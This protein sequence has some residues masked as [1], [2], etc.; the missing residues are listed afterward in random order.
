MAQAKA[1][2]TSCNKN[3]TR[4]KQETCLNGAAII[5][6]DGHEI[7]I[8][9]AMIQEACENLHDAWYFPKGNQTSV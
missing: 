8:T 4:Q 1:Y 6:E 7:P 5:D 3:I 9:E 2:S